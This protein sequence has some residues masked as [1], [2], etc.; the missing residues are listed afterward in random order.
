MSDIG[1]RIKEMRTMLNVSQRELAETID[2]SSGA[3]SSI[4]AGARNPPFEAF[5]KI[6]ELAHKASFN[7]EWLLFNDGEPLKPADE[8]RI[9]LTEDESDLVEMYNLLGK[10]GKRVVMGTATQQTQ[11]AKLEGGKDNANLA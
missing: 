5:M 9:R 11:M 2:L 3:I 4:E 7:L 6:C 8:V 10:E 1:S